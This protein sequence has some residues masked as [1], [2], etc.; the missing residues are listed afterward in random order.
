MKKEIYLNIII[1]FAS[2]SICFIL[3]E[4]LLRLIPVP[5]IELRAA[6]DFDNDIYLYRYAPHSRILRWDI[7]N[8][9][10]ERKVN[11]E[12]YLDR[13]HTI[14]K[15]K[16][17][18]RIG[19]FG[20]SFVEAIQ[21][22]LEHTFVRIIENKLKNYT[23][24]T[25]AFGTTGHGTVHSFLKSKKYAPYFDLDM[26]VYVFCD[27]D[28]GDQIKE[29]KRADY[30]PYVTIV[31]DHLV[32]DNE[33]VIKSLHEYR[34]GTVKKFF[35]NN[36]MV[37]QNIYRRLSLI[38]KYGI[39]LSASK[40]DMQMATQT[41]HKSIPNQ[42]D[43]PSLWPKAYRMEAM[44]FGEKVIAEWA[45]DMKEQNRKFV[46]CYIPRETEWGKELTKQD[47]WKPWLKHYC[48]KIKID[49]IDPTESF[50]VMAQKGIKI[51]DGHFSVYGHQA[52]AEAF[53]NWFISNNKNPAN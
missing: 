45:N 47:S 5:G 36:S 46:I 49:F 12:G 18:Y 24:E 39:K 28:L 41:E 21:V 29:I 43:L 38:K 8:E 48:E 15:P 32:V 19:F 16:N 22:S 4:I 6:M 14:E 10:L 52:F 25:L 9:L 33:L 11:A 17:I 27:N 30:L 3:C 13:E 50:M 51:Y 20:D 2:L 23:V 35:Y 1:L 31:G 37:F 34:W 53:V 44:Q 42:N 40:Q 7:R 26:V